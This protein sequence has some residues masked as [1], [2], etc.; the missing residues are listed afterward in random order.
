[1]AIDFVPY[2]HEHLPA[3]ARFSQA[4]WTRP[5]GDDFH[6]WRYERCPNQHGLLALRDGECLAA[7]WFFK[8]AFQFGLR[9]V[10]V[11]EVLDWAN[12]PALRGTGLG[13]RL[14]QAVM[15]E[16]LPILNVGGSEETRRYLPEMGWRSLGEVAQFFLPLTG[17][18]VGRA[19]ERKMGLPTGLA[20]AAFRVTGHY[21]F[22]PRAAA[23]PREADARVARPGPE[24]LELYAGEAARSLPL[25]D[26][27]RLQWLL[28][29]PAAMGAYELRYFTVAGKLRGWSLTRTVASKSGRHAQII[30]L[31]APPGEDAL[32][33]WMLS[34]LL[35]EFAERGVD[36]V[37]AGTSSDALRRA[38]L[39][40]RFLRRPAL[41]VQYWPAGLGLPPEPFVLGNNTSDAAL[42]PYPLT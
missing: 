34:E 22:R 36:D 24:L 7:V 4:A 41:P 32:Y 19:L 40:N 20:I 33:E 2:A 21:W 1:M 29:A 15:K 37:Y 6:R 10:D 35:M 27:A 28:D 12:L 9:R 39:K 42:L 5:R 8:R 23:A 25:P 13:V 31:Y 38:L 11:L 3:V 26:L 17:A 18:R 14:L 30:E 16:P